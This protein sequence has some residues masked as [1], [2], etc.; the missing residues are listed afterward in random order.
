MVDRAQAEDKSYSKTIMI[1][2]P[3]VLPEEAENPTELVDNK[4]YSSSNS[5]SFVNENNLSDVL[6]EKLPESGASTEVLVSVNQK[7]NYMKKFKL[8]QKL[9]RKLKKRVSKMLIVQNERFSNQ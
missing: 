5:S 7:H 9:E 4:L 6:S 3:S 1:E 8:Q 2:R